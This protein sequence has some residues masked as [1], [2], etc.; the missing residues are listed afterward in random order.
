[1]AKLWHDSHVFPT[2]DMILNKTAGHHRHFFRQMV[3]LKI[4]FRRMWKRFLEK[5]FLSNFEIFW[6][7]KKPTIQV[8]NKKFS[9]NIIIWYAFYSKFAT[10]NAFEK[11]HFPEKPQFFFGK[12]TKIHSKKPYYFSRILQQSRNNLVIKNFNSQNQRTLDTF[13][14]RKRNE[15][16]TLTL[17]GCIYLHV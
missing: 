16:K 9:W 12:K 4:H 17:S 7:L 14:W 15:N 1:M 8:K 2:L 13:V 11:S 10:F 3:L 5:C 6:C